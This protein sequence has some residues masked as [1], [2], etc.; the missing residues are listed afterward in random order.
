MNVILN[1]ITIYGAIFLYICKKLHVNT[2]E[3]FYKNKT[4]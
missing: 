4:E 2:H 1:S 3:R